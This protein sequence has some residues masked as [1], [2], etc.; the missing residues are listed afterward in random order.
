MLD[1]QIPQ[2]AHALHGRESAGD[3]AILDEQ[4]DHVGEVSQTPEIAGYLG[5]LYHKQTQLRHLCQILQTA[6]NGKVSKMQFPP[7]PKP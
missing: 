4:M 3:H 1:L 2:V 5:I 6:P 7:P